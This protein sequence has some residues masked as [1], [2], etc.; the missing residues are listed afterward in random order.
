[1]MRALANSARAEH[2]SK[3]PVKAI[4]NELEELERAD[5][6]SGRR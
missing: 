2:E 5:P 4:W 1:M 6:I 3:T